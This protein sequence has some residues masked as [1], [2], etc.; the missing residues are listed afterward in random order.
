MGAGKIQESYVKLFTSTRVT[1]IDA[2]S[3]QEGNSMKN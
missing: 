1:N 2:N 3:S